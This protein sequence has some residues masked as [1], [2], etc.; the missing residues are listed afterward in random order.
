M[1]IVI[2]NK[3]IADFM[4]GKPFN[5]T[6]SCTLTD[7]HN[8]LLPYHGL[9]VTNTIE[10]G[11]GKT[12]KYHKDLGWLVPAIVKIGQLEPNNVGLSQHL[13]PYTYGIDK[14]YKHVV[15]YIKGHNYRLNEAK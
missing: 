7:S 6:G 2:N 13:N 15:E 10:V 5:E 4:G 1:S 11:H 8:Y 3:L 14:L 9:V 12:M